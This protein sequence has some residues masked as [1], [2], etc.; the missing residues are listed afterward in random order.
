M[1]ARARR[2]G[3]DGGHNGASVQGTRHMP[4]ASPSSCVR[5][6]SR[7][8]AVS[9]GVVSATAPPT[10]HAGRPVREMI[11]ASGAR[12]GD[13]HAAAPPGAE[14]CSRATHVSH[15]A[16]GA[17][18]NALETARASHRSRPEAEEPCTP[19]RFS[20]PCPW[21]HHQRQGWRGVGRGARTGGALRPLTRC[22]HSM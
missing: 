21:L 2:S 12:Q 17:C 7:D 5:R 16:V 22:V 14:G 9:A 15:D 6:E 4:R 18:Q 1:G 3:A 20:M 13:Q 8:R 19:R 10:G 11:S